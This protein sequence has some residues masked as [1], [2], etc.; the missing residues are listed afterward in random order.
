VVELKLPPNA[1]IVAASPA[2]RIDGQTLRFSGAL[3]ID[4]VIELVFRQ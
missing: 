1:A 3:A 4:Q 2:P